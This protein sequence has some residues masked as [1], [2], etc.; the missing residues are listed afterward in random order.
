MTTDNENTDVAP[1]FRA[2]FDGV[3]PV[4]GQNRP[5]V[6]WYMVPSK[7]MPEMNEAYIIIVLSDLQGNKLPIVYSVETAY[8]LIEQLVET[9]NTDPDVALLGSSM[10]ERGPLS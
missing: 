6:G 10:P 7:T 9:L 3:G 1:K 2:V 8:A 5:E 4:V